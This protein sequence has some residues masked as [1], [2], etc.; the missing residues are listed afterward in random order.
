MTT[1]SPDRRHWWD[2]QQWRPV[3]IE[4]YTNHAAH[5]IMCVLT[6]GAWLPVYGAVVWYNRRVT[7]RRRQ[8]R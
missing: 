7:K 6:L 1:Y 3:V 2:G 8:A 4:A 5:R